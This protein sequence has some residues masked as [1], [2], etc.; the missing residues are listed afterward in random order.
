MVLYFQLFLYK[1]SSRESVNHVVTVKDFSK[2]FLVITESNWMTNLG[3]PAD[4]ELLLNSRIR[5]SELNIKIL[6]ISKNF[7]PD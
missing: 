4:R 5:G 1:V 7:F 2:V 3:Q 6:N